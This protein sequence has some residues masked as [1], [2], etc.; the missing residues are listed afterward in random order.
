MVILVIIHQHS[1]AGS[2]TRSELVLVLKAVQIRSV[3]PQ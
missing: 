3:I 2:I 1:L